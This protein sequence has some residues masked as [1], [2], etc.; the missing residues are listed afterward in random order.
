MDSTFH[1][2]NKSLKEYLEIIVRRRWFALSAFLLVIVLVLAYTFFAPKKYIA[3]TV[4]MIE[5]NSSRTLSLQEALTMEP[6][7]QEFYQTQYRI[8]SSRTLAERVINDLKLYKMEEFVEKNKDEQIGESSDGEADSSNNILVEMARGI[9]AKRLEIT[10]VRNSRL[11]TIGFISYN[12]QVAAQ[13]ANEVAKAYIEYTMERKLKINQMAV[14]FLTKRIDEQRR[15]LEASQIALQSYMQEQGLTNYISDQFNEMSAQK[16]AELHSKLLSAQT[17]RKELEAN[18]NL[19]KQVLGD[20]SKQKMIPD[21]LQSQVIQ[22]IMQRQ[23]EV[24]KNMAELNQ[25]YGENHPKITSVKAELRDLQ[26]TLNTE[27]HKIVSSMEVKYQVAKAKENAIE[28]SLE[29]ERIRLMD[30][31][32][33]AIGYSVL[34]R[35]VE[36]NKQLYDMLLSKVKEARVSEEI[37]VGSIT[38]VDAAIVPKVP[39]SPKLLANLIIAIVGGLAAGIVLVLGLDHLDNTIKF[40]EHFNK[41]PEVSYLGHIPYDDE[42]ISQGA[43]VTSDKGGVNTGE[44]RRL[45]LKAGEAFR[46]IRTAISLS[47]AEQ[48]PRIIV[49]SSS[50]PAEGKSFI[51]A[52]LALSFAVTNEKTLLIDA[53]MRKPRQHKIWNVTKSYG[54]SSIL[55]GSAGPDKCI[56]KDVSQ[57]LD[58]IAAG[59]IPPNPAELIQSSTMGKYL[60]YLSKIYSRIIIDSP[61]ILPVAD[62]LILGHI[63]DGVLLV[64]SAG[65][66]NTYALNQAI[67]RMSTARV[68]ILGAVLNLSDSKKSDYY[69]KGYQYKYYYGY[70]Y[71]E[72]EKQ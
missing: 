20:S 65:K 29:A 6:S 39:Y 68:N 41:I 61:P 72:K 52:N 16:M 56:Q 62:P 28:D 5:P 38:I 66:T 46:N 35:E 1:S 34:N 3:E 42:I 49:V 44:E 45:S 14:N 7:A 48:Q 18:Y 71:G 25:K 17:E 64:V 54:L 58:V 30:I 4:L 60:E 33:K 59:P 13:V 70:H 55:S 23:L 26:S 24:S 50:G 63:T 51:A 21:I 67:E 9:F 12:P 8:I 27:M 2:V 37:D 36:T 22:T 19:A 57:F 40:P 32:K 69:Y 53:D 10:P 47:R 43:I 11:C 31:R 15:K